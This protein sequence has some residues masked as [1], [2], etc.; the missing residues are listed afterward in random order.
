MSFGKPYWPIRNT[1][2]AAA[3]GTLGIELDAD[4]PYIEAVDPEGRSSKEFYFR[5]RYT[6]SDTEI[7]VTEY[8]IGAWRERDK[9]E[10]ENPTHPLVPMRRVYDERAI[11]LG[12]VKGSILPPA[13]RKVRDPHITPLIRE[14]A[15]LRAC[16]EVMISFTDRKFYFPDARKCREIV[17]QARKPQ[18]RSGPQ[19]MD[20]FLT[21]LDKLLHIAKAPPVLMTPEDNKMLLLSADAPKKAQ[22]FWLDKLEEVGGQ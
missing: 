7:H 19:W 10:R 21:N 16:G 11:L 14:A 17:D 22:D 20:M 13:P 3:L 1:A 6:V 12:I 18:G 2:L 4:Q 9:F 5:D 8:L 15:L